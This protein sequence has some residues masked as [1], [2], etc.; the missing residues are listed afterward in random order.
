MTADPFA[1]LPQILLDEFGVV[2]TDNSEIFFAYFFAQ[3]VPEVPD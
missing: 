3:I 2:G 1:L